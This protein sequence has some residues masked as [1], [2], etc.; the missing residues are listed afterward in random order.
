MPVEA[1]IA[2]FAFIAL[3]IGWVILPSFIRKH[4]ESASEEAAE[5]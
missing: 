2:V 3:F 5:G 1:I 4:H